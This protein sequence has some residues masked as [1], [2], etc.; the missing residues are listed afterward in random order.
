MVGLGAAPAVFQF[1]F[2]LFLPETP[3]WLVQVGKFKLAEQA[4]ERVYRYV[5]ADFLCH[6][7]PCG[8]LESRSGHVIALSISVFRERLCVD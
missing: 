8:L 3:R 2:L 4:L 1:G 7:W 6:P 5:A